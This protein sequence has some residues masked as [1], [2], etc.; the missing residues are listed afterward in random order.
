LVAGHD[1]EPIKGKNGD[2]SA[3]IVE[4]TIDWIARHTYPWHSIRRLMAEEEAYSPSTIPILSSLRTVARIGAGT[5]L[6]WNP[7]NSGKTLQR[8]ARQRRGF[9]ARRGPGTGSLLAGN[10]PRR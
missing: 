9:H 10:R 7:A 2:K 1:V 3:G 6:D 4:M 5:N 8:P